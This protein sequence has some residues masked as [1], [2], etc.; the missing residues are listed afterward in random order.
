MK[1]LPEQVYAAYTEFEAMPKWSKRL[2]SVRVTKREGNTVYL[3]SEG[4]SSRGKRRKAGGALRLLPPDKVESES[5]TRFTRTKRTVAFEKV[6][7]GA[8]TKVTATLDVQVKG[9]W[10]IVLSTRVEK[11][12]A[13]S[14]ALEELASFARF[15]ESP[16][17]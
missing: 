16:P 5:E 13:E 12:D 14:S 15:V 6:P 10:A 4:V 3:E 7:E 9:L 17:Q 2:T 11:D 8:G 1:A